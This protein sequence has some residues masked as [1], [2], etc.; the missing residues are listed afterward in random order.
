MIVLIEKLPIK[1]IMKNWY[2]TYIYICSFVRI[3]FIC[4]LLYLV[5]D[6]VVSVVH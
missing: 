1:F 5:F 4:F 3:R 2:D 6:T